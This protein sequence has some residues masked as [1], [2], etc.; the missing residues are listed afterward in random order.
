MSYPA[1]DPKN[2][3]FGEIMKEVKLLRMIR[4]PNVVELISTYLKE[5]EIGYEF[6][7]GNE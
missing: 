7:N 6:D 5:K 4:H 3:K 2:E 1:R